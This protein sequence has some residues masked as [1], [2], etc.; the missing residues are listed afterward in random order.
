MTGRPADES[1]PAHRIARRARAGGL[2]VAAAESLTAGGIAQEL[3][4]APGAGEWFAGSVVAYRP[5]VK[6]AV[7]GVEPGPV[8]SA[9]AAEQMANGAARLLRAD[10]AV[11]VT[12]AGGPGPT[13]GRAAG[14]AFIAVVVAGADGPGRP[15]REYRFDGEPADVVRRATRQAL[16]DLAAAVEERS[17]ADRSGP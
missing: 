5:E 6:F 4:A 3:A 9:R 14:T 7:L 12:G 13:E 2:L 1:G 8:I 16:M 10:V 15:A 11:G 17:S